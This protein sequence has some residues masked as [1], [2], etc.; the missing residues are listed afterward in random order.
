MPVVVRE[1]TI[2]APV[3][4]VW[5][6]LADV[7]RQPLWMTDLKSVELVDAD[8]VGVGTRA[9]A[10]VRMFGLGQRDPIE[11]S[12]Y[13]PPSRFGV[14]HLGGFAGTGDFWLTRLSAG[15]TRVRWRE[16]LRPAVDAFGLP[17]PVARLLAP[18]ARVTDP[19]L[20]PV[21]ALVFRA[22][23]RRLKELVEGR[24]AAAR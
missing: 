8:P 1:K 3:E 6:V 2:A 16:E 9:I 11:I 14:R 23:L 12:V 17:A 4:A 21:F 7:P 19:L 20:Y 10:T 24:T 15:W 5:A 13:Q 18:V 22:D